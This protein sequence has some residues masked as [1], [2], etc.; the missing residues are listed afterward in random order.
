MTALASRSVAPERSPSGDPHA[1]WRGVAGGAGATGRAEIRAETSDSASHPAWLALGAGREIVA[2]C[3]LMRLRPGYGRGDR[4]EEREQ[5]PRA[6]A[7]DDGAAG[8]GDLPGI[9]GSTRRSVVDGLALSRCDP[10]TIRDTWLSEVQ[11]A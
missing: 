3:S 2:V 8:S 10:R 6:A 7:P 5:R 11:A 1:F 9:A 4:P